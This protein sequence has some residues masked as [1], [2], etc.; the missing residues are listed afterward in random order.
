MRSHATWFSLGCALAGVVLALA[1]LVDVTAVTATPATSAM[2]VLQSNATLS[3]RSAEGPVESETIWPTPQRPSSM[4]PAPP[5]EDDLLRPTPDPIPV[6]DA[7]W[8]P[9][10][11]VTPALHR[12]RPASPRWDPD[13]A[14]LP[15]A[16][17]VVR[18]VSV[19]DPDSAVTPQL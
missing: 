17:I 16:S 2:P 1:V 13:T 5:D 10:S 4:M 18:R 9:D 6:R 12:T 7:F 3:T 14:A 19:W 8:D 11:V 15:N